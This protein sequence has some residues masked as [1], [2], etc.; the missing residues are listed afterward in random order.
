MSPD[1]FRLDGTRV[2]DSEQ[3]SKEGG[4]TRDEGERAPGKASDGMV[5]EVG[6]SSGP[7]FCVVRAGMG[8]GGG[9]FLFSVYFQ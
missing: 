9:F 2:P 4:M 3:K 1:G 6:G 8:V 7:L 5:V